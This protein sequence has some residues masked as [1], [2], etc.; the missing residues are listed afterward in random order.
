MS[1]RDLSRW[2]VSDRAASELEYVIS[3]AKRKA[4]PGVP[5]VTADEA[6]RGEKVF[7]SKSSR[8][9]TRVLF[10]S[11]NAELLNPTQ[12]TL[13][14]YI[15]ISELFD[16][17][18][19]II[20]RQG[21]EP[22][23][24]VLRPAK[25]VWIYT[26]AS[27]IWWKTP[28]AGIAM[29]ERQLEFASGFR[30][31]LIIA[32]DPF[33]SAVVAYQLGKKYNRPTQLHVLDDFSGTGFFKKRDNNF[34]RWLMTFFLIPKFSSVRTLTKNVATVIQ[35]RFDIVDL[36]VLPKYQN[37]QA[38]IDSE[39]K[40]DLKERYKPLI[41][42]ML[43][44][45]KLD[46][47][48][49]L[50]KIMDATN[51]LLR[52]PRVGL[53]V[54]GDGPAKK[55]FE[56]KAKALGIEGQVVFENRVIDPVLYLKSAN[57]LLVSDTTSYSEELVLKGAAAGIPMIMSSTEK[58]E[59][60]FVDGKSAFICDP[61]DTEVFNAK[62]SDLLNHI[63][64]RHLFTENSQNIIRRQFH[65]DQNNYQVAYRTSIEQ[66]FFADAGDNNTE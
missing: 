48:S 45:G 14:G 56:K 66:A 21:I 15:N 34:C 38:L 54:L 23:N 9:V 27:R 25:N 17:I 16:E 33:E 51:S 24:P 32:R 49:T 5:S 22:K 44:I 36:D 58:R 20:L 29:A 62:M 19:I 50:H 13:D 55:E 41:F 59:D 61:S 37:Y 7:D 53:I 40:I 35:K 26:A 4:N 46:K 1:K 47:D 57:I 30:P 6:I 63:E 52:N 60:T 2:D 11:R 64:T 39:H 18:H 10:I 3:S 12:Q 65:N 8:N 43:Y 42:F 28:G 31:D